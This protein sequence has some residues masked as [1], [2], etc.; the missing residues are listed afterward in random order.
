MMKAA[1][2]K[3][4][5]SLALGLGILFTSCTKE[6]E[7]DLNPT[8]TLD[9]G[10]QYVA[11]DR[12]VEPGT[13]FTVK[14]TANKGPD[15]KNIDKIEVKVSYAG[16]VPTR[17]T[18]I[19]NINQASY[20]LVRNLR[21]RDVEGTERWIFTATDKDGKTAERSFTI[22]VK[23]KDTQQ[24]TPPKS[25]TITLSNTN[26]FASSSDG[27]VYNATNGQANA[28]KVDLT[29]F[30]SGTSKNNMAS[31]EARKNSANY[32]TFAVNWGVVQTEFRNV[33]NFTASD[34]DALNDETRIKTL[35]DAGTPTK[36]VQNPDGTRFNE[37][38]GDFVANKVIAFQNKSTGKYGLIKIVSVAANE[39][40]SASIALKVQN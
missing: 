4:L 25:F 14:L 16:A 9:G 21:A 19:E 37:A 8:L 29:Y 34:F 3:V 18:L 7:K 35:F 11:A 1:L 39:N 36:V 26:A 13:R 10:N 5:V 40:G 24:P 2:L 6:E 12:Q 15:G 17:D 27:I 32:G 20:T 28:S 30:F 33:T 23:K 38:S 22:T 31:P